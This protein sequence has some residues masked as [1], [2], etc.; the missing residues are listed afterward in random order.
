EPKLAVFGGKLHLTATAWDPSDVTAHRTNVLT[1]DS[2]DAVSFSSST[3]AGFVSGFAAGRPREILSTLWIGTWRADELVP[4]TASNA[5]AIYTS[6]DGKAY[7]GSSVAPMPVGPG[8]RQAEFIVRAN[9][10]LWVI[11]P[12]RAVQGDQDR[13]TFCHTALV[14]NVSWTCWSTT[15]FLVDAPVLFEQKGALYVAARRDVGTLRRTSIFEV[16]EADEDLQLVADLPGTQGDT[17][18]PGITRLDANRLLLTYH[19]TSTLDA[20]VQAL[21]HE[22][23]VLEAESHGYATDVMAVQVDMRNIPAGR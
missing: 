14:A 22:P 5:F 19:S 4:G 23:T 7:T 16:A 6:T 20:R 8:A 15:S 11:V 13:T 18:S 3:P 12:E 1:W 17:G 2:A 9:N 21:G 10:T